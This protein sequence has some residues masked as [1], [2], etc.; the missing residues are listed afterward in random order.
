MEYSLTGLEEATIEIQSSVGEL[1]ARSSLPCRSSVKENL[2]TVLGE[3]CDYINEW[4]DDSNKI[5]EMSL[6]I[7]VNHLKYVLVGMLYS[8]G[9]IL[10]D[11][12]GIK[13]LIKCINK[14]DYSESSHESMSILCSNVYIQSVERIAALSETI[15]RIK[16]IY[17]PA[18]YRSIQEPDLFRTTY[19]SLL[20][21][22][23]CVITDDSLPVSY[24]TYD[25]LMDWCSDNHRGHIMRPLR[26]ADLYK[27]QCYMKKYPAEC[28]VIGIM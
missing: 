8:D 27:K 26:E 20:S 24:N 19:E 25:K 7:L 14:S 13:V 22:I 10:A 15:E 4:L 3:Y 11:D 16:T 18:I 12:L 21:K 1:E 28:M 6:E 23:S 5:T 17:Q 2:D 9:V